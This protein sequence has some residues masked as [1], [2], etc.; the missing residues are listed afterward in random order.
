MYT[1]R[2]NQVSFSTNPCLGPATAQFEAAAGDGNST[3]NQAFK[4]VHLNFQ[5]Q[6]LQ[7]WAD[8]EIQPK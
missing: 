6:I 5:L 7:V 8:S 2:L 4:K 1:I 3:R